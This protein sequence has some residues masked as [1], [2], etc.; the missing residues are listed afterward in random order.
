VP[1]ASL[2]EEG[3]RANNTLVDVSRFNSDFGNCGVSWGKVIEY[4]VGKDLHKFE[5]SVDGEIHYVSFEDV[6]IMLPKS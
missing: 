4:D 3:F 5:F 6:L 1:I 2:T